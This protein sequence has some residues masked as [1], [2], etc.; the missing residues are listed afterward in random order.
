MAFRILATRPTPEAARSTLH[1][2]RHTPPPPIEM[3]QRVA[4]IT[5]GTRGIGLGIAR[6]LLREGFHVAVNGVRA[7][8]EISEVL[9]ELRQAGPDVVYCRGNVATAADRSAIMEKV[10]SHFG[11]LNILV[12]NAGIAPSVRADLL[13]ASEES[14][15]NVLKTNLQGPYFLTQQAARW[16]VAQKDAE[17][18]AFYC[19]INV[20]SISA[21]HASPNRGEYCVSKAGIAMATQLW[22]VRLGEHDIPVYEIRPGIIETDMTAGV[23]EKYD[24]Q[25][26]DGLTLQRR[27][28]LPEDVGR[29]AAALARGDLRYSTGQVVMVDGGL[30]VGRF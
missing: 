13:D 16:M 17:E 26:A 21:T 4:L 27:W 14:F 10:R 2:P 22:A 6:A 18:N 11:R 28:G 5:G 3:K 1:A 20:G 19:I 7:E 9:G 15:V 25:I 8:E 12:N 23:K 29:T 30:G 24:R